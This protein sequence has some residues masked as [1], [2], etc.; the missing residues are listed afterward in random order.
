MNASI[1]SL[2][3][4]TTSLPSGS[5]DAPGVDAF[6]V[7]TSLAAAPPASLAAPTCRTSTLLD[8]TGVLQGS[9]DRALSAP[10]PAP[11]GAL[12]F[13]RDTRYALG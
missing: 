8:T 2:L 3:L 12:L 10:L 5:A 6:V 4:A 7:P 9:A 1:V 11:D 13:M